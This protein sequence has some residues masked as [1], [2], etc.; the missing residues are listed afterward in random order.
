MV[1]VAQATVIGTLQAVH[2]VDTS[3]P[4]ITVVAGNPLEIVDPTPSTAT[5]TAVLMLSR[6]DGG[7]GAAGD[8]ASIDFGIMN[9]VG[10]RVV[11]V[12]FSAEWIDATSGSEDAE[13]VFSSRAFGILAEGLRVR[14]LGVDLQFAT[15]FAFVLSPNAQLT[16][17]L[18]IS[19]V[20]SDT[21]VIPQ[22]VANQ[23]YL[24]N[25][26]ADPSVNLN[27]GNARAF[28][29]IPLGTTIVSNTPGD[30]IAM[31]SNVVLDVATV[32]FGGFVAVSGEIRFRQSGSAFGAGNL[33]KIS[34]TFTNEIGSSVSIGSQYTFVHVGRYRADGAFAQSNFFHRVCLFQ[35]TWQAFNGA[36]QTITT[37]N[38]G[39]LL[40]PIQ[41]AGVTFTNM[42]DWEWAAGTFSGTTTN[43]SH[44]FWPATNTPAA[45]IFEG[46]NSA[47]AAS[48]N[49]RFIRH[50]GT[51]QADFGGVVAFG[52]GA[53]V[54]VTLVRGAADRLDLGA[55]DSLRISD[56]GELQFGG[57]VVLRRLVANFLTM[58]DGDS[59]RIT[60]G[61]LFF[62]ASGSINLREVATDVLALA[63]GDSFRIE[64]GT[65]QFAGTA[66]Q[67]SR[68]AGELLLTGA[69]VRTSAALEVDGTFNHDGTLYGQ[70]GAV[71]VAQDT[72]WLIS[73]VST[74]RAYDANSTNL[75]E[76]ADT[77]GT[78]IETVLKAQGVV[79]A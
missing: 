24:G 69:I 74:L 71:P 39:G 75:D 30:W 25:T 79:G 38:V 19:V 40:N 28:D 35:P 15:P 5:S 70:Y 12:R 4:H 76:I 36:T 54:D 11:A 44:L 51:A 65:L 33:F 34:G 78:L 61:N 72:G 73:N 57:D 56:T 27:R 55:G 31:A 68:T 29:I 50:T 17:G 16:D 7:N 9:S 64:D 46:I 32:S 26:I 62:G 42:R 63:T 13:V 47:L 21:Y 18:R 67:I 10:V 37:V 52:A 2:D 14:P 23:F 48:A 22:T 59:F 20:A 3:Q 77:L 8:G 41:D 58:N 1:A 43:R 45:T 66:E 6:D 53:T 60:T 49:H